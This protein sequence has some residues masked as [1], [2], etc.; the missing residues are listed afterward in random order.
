M[1]IALAG[2]ALVAALAALCPRR[3]LPALAF[4]GACALT[5]RALGG[6]AAIVECAGVGAVLL[7][8]RRR[9]VVARARRDAA[10]AAALPDALDLLAACVEGGATLDH[11]LAAVAPH[12]DGA[13]GPRFGACAAQLRSTRPRREVLRALG[14]PSVRELDRAGHALAAADEL[15]S[16]LA[17]TLTEQAAMQR[18]L[19]RLGVRER[20]AAAGPKIALVVAVTLVPSALV[21]VLGSQALSLLAGV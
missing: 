19:A 10:L 7:G 6:S 16:P 12:V 21:L 2:L 1:S 11:A 14:G 4:L 5:W 9:D 20:A 13:L 3:I 17:S 8:I 18:E 15:G